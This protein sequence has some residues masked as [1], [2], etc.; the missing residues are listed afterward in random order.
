[1]SIEEL[2]RI[3][4]PH[5]LEEIDDGR[6]VLEGFSEDDWKVFFTFLDKRTFA[7]GD[8][9]VHQGGGD[10]SLFILT[11][12]SLEVRVET[13]EKSHAVD[14]MKEGTLFGEQSFADGNSRTATV[15]A[16]SEGELY[17]LSVEAFERLG[18]EH[19]SLSLALMRDV[20]RVLSLRCRMLQGVRRRLLAEQA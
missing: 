3:L 8:V 19:P 5:G 10:R 6:G 12:G 15:A 2:P 20:A 16:T 1:M 11:A 17:R 13:G 18:Q 14:T 4:R 7:A 9:L